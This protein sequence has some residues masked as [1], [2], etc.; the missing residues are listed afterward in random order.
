M[1]QLTILY[2]DFPE[3]KG[4]PIFVRAM[5]AL[6]LASLGQDLLVITGYTATSR[7]KQTNTE[8]HLKECCINKCVV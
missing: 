8:R 6:L 1:V 7:S 4:K 2:Q 3:M 5:E